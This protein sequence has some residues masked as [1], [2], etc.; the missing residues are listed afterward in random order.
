MTAWVVLFIVQVR[1]VAVHRVRLHIRL[2]V[3]GV[4]LTALVI[5]LGAV[6]AVSAAAR[7]SGPQPPLV[8]LAIPLGD[9]LIFAILAGTS[10]YLRR[11]PGIHKRL[12]LLAALSILSSAI[13]RLPLEV[14]Q[15]P[16]GYFG[17]IDIFVMSS[18][19]Y[20][21]IRNHK[22]NR[23]FA[24]GVLLIIISQPLRLMVSATSAWMEF[25][26]WLVR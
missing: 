17:V 1:L 11:R 10:L 14:L 16:P 12:M 25:A 7:G 20:D 5:I 21:T 13:A 9:I 23:A 22:L 19:A 24:L 26:T 6:T 18:L 15:T 2:G 3:F 4:F 8:F